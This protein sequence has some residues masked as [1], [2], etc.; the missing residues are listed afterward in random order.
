MGDVQL[1]SSRRSTPKAGVVPLSADNFYFAG[2]RD[3][4]LRP[5]S[6][7]RPRP[8]LRIPAHLPRMRLMR[9]L[10]V[11]QYM[12]WQQ[13]QQQQLEQTEPLP[14]QPSELDLL[15]TSAIFE[16]N[17]TAIARHAAI[18]TAA[19]WE[20]GDGGWEAQPERR[21]LEESTASAVL[22]GVPASAATSAIPCTSA[23][24]SPRGAALVPPEA[25]G[26]AA[27]ADRIRQARACAA[28][29]AL[30]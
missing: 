4:S 7:F 1:S 30:A 24:R 9:D 21:W 14:P 16:A 3:G 11:Q 19:G 18:T 25:V 2:K 8:V 10:L 17:A 13:Q 5:V 6:S 29:G 28:L 12:E 20:A 15:A 26:A 23:A 27:H 22:E